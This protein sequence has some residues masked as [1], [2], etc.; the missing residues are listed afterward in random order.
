M[1]VVYVAKR[2]LFDHYLDPGTSQD[3]IKALVS[4]FAMTKYAHWRYE[5]ELRCWASLDPAGPDIQFYHYG[6]KIALRHVYIGAQSAITRQ[7]VTDAL[8][9]ELTP[10]VNITTCRLAFRSFQVVTQRNANLWH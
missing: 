4:R 7:M 1:P 8:G 6:R 2:L 3:E 10:M 9:D 5:K